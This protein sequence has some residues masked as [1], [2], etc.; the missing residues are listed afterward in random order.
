MNALA[1]SASLVLAAT[2]AVKMRSCCSSAG[3]GPT[4]ST[5]G[6][7]S[8]GDEKYAKLGLAFG[9][10]RDDLRRPGQR[11]GLGLHR[12]ADAETLE[13]P[14]DLGAGRARGHG[15]DGLRL[16]QRLLQRF[17]RADVGLGGSRADCD[18]EAHASNVGRRPGREPGLGSG[19]LEHL[20]RDDA[21]SN[22]PPVVASLI[23]SGAVPKRK[24]SL[25]PEAFS[26][27][28]PSSRNGP[29]MPPPART[30]SSAARAWTIDI[31][32][33][34]KPSIRRR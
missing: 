22:G 3:N 28:A 33:S 27:C 34:A 1:A 4:R 26:N 29:I 6:A 2:A 32:V 7:A 25:W 11:L 9:D 21:G 13:C 8:V 15:G 17:G 24:T 20:A 14:Q 16:E 19:V 31:E 10:R 18:A 30:G 5:P 12:L 23:S